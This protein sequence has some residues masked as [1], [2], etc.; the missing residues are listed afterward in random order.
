MSALLVLRTCLP[1]NLDFPASDGCSSS[2]TLNITIVALVPFVIVR[3]LVLSLYCKIFD[4]E[5]ERELQ[6]WCCT[7]MLRVA[8]IEATRVSTSMINGYIILV[9]TGDEVR[10]GRV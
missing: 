6:S 1:H 2:S 5:H 8:L 9:R 10:N 3:L 4:E 7:R